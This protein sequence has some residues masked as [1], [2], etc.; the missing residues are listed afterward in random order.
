MGVSGPRKSSGLLVGGAGMLKATCRPPPPLLPLCPNA[1]QARRMLTA[2]P[3][4][5]ATRLSP[6]PMLPPHLRAPAPP[7]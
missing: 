1:M 6:T 2:L 7:S 3:S 5:P 4:L